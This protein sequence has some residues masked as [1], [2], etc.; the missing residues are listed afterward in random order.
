MR[1]VFQKFGLKSPHVRGQDSGNAAALGPFILDDVKERP[2][3]LLYLTGDKNRDTLPTILEQGGLTLL[4]LQ[5][6]MTQGSSTFGSTLD[7]KLKQVDN[8]MFTFFFWI[9]SLLRMIR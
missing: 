2:A 7:S 9:S 1:T 6:Y 3:R 5:V 8:G 4:S